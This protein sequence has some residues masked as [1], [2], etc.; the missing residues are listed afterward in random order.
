MTNISRRSFIKSG[1]LLAGAAAL[2]FSSRSYANV[3]GA[4]NRVRIAIAGCGGRGGELSGFFGKLDGVEIV[5]LADPNKNTLANRA[6]QIKKDFGNDP[7]AVADI[8]ELLED[9]NIDAVAVSTCNHWHAL[10][11][12][13]AC[14]A[15]KDVYIEKPCS[16]KLFEG[17]KCIEAAEKYN[18]LM[19]H[20]TQRRSD[21]IWA[22]V[23]AAIQQNRYG[24]LVAAKVHASRPRGPLGFKPTGDPPA[25][26]DWN[27]WI[28]P[29]AM[30]PYHENLVPYNWHWFWNTGN[31]EIG[32][33]GVHYFDLCNWAMQVKHP[34]SVISF[35]TRF[36][37]DKANDYKDQAET[38]NIQFV[39]YDFDGIP[40]IYQ[41]CNIAGP[42]D[43]WQ[44][45]EEAEF[46]TEQGILRG[47]RF[48]PYKKEGSLEVG[49]AVALQVDQYDEPAPGGNYGNFI[50][51]VR[52]RN[53][54]KLNAPISNG[55]YS[56]GICHWG[57]ASYQMGEK[58]DVTPI[59]KIREQMGSNPI[60]QKSI[61]AVLENAVRELGVELKEIP[62]KVGPKLLIDG[63][64]EKF[65]D[66]A[67]AD[68]MLTREPRGEFAV[69]E[70]V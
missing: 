59:E 64:A 11:A 52:D 6:A 48:F 26:L 50:N 53:A 8:R 28:G 21:T 39:L 65:I 61:E 58:G 3:V 68:A 24:K 38:P 23:A 35:G 49:D 63:K 7:K 34:N 32:N 1:A 45:Q 14:Q 31:G 16:Q 54:V 62:F 51:A 19:Q 41:S 69:P 27:L 33:N 42:K 44:P 17:R 30:T 36:V 55:H 70:Q 5:G 25:T 66:N 46:Y 56:A 15:G 18:R 20:G 29:A 40:L 9:K 47:G 13:W 60:M 10:I 2:P 22:K 12:I 37:K 4:N 67:E 43:K 57:N